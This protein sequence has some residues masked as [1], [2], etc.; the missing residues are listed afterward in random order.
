MQEKQTKRPGRLTETEAAAY[1]G[2][3]PQ[4]LAVWR[5]TGRYGLPFIRVGN[6]RVQYWQTDLD[7]WLDQQTV[8]VNHD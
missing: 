2:V 6:R 5:S 4:T 7:A 8:G 1:I 3:K